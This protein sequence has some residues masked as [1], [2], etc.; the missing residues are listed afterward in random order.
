MHPIT[1]STI[2]AA[3]LLPPIAESAIGLTLEARAPIERVQGRPEDR[4]R[5]EQEDRQRR[6]EERQRVLDQQ[7]QTLDD[8]R[9]QLDQQRVIIEQQRQQQQQQ[10]DDRRR[11]RNRGL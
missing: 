1:V 6:S 10:D 2:A 4:M 3:L 9:K 11:D 8:Q 5:L 7:R